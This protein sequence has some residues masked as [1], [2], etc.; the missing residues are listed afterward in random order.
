MGAKS[1]EAN[2][3]AA[4]VGPHLGRSQPN[5]CDPRRDGRP[6]LLRL[7]F[8]DWLHGLEIRLVALVGLVLAFWWGALYTCFWMA[9]RSRS[10]ER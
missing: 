5:L 2:E 9:A 6:I 7:Q 10:D 4:Q 1:G 8:G 3:L